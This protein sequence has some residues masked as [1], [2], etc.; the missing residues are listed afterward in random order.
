MRLLRRRSQTNHSHAPRS[1]VT[2]GQNFP[3]EKK[4]AKRGQARRPSASCRKH[5][6]KKRA[7]QI[8]TLQSRACSKRLPPGRLLRAPVGIINDRERSE[9]AKAPRQQELGRRGGR[10]RRG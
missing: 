5:G 4:W 6:I 3:C 1:V 2:M 9:A 10:L 7:C 8:K